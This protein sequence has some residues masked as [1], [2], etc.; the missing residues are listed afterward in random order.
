VIL[1]VSF[2]EQFCA[3]ELA[4]LTKSRKV[5]NGRNGEIKTYCSVDLRQKG[6]RYSL[7][8]FQVA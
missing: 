3:R 5:A 7:M 8:E 1:H 2:F 4:M 6:K